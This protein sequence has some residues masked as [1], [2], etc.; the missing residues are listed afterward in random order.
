[1][2]SRPDSALVL[3]SLHALEVLKECKA[4]NV[5]PG[6]VTPRIRMELSHYVKCSKKVLNTLMTEHIVGRINKGHVNEYDKSG[7]TP[8]HYIALFDLHHLLG[9]LLQTGV[10]FEL[11]PDLNFKV[12]PLQLATYLYPNS[13]IR[14]MLRTAT[15]CIADPIKH[16]QKKNIALRAQNPVGA[17]P[18]QNPVGNTPLV[19]VQA[20]CDSKGTAFLPDAFV[21]R[22]VTNLQWVYHAD[23]LALFEKTKSLE[24]AH[25]CFFDMRQALKYPNDHQ[26]IQRFAS[27]SPIVHTK[28]FMEVQKAEE[29]L[30]RFE[31]IPG[32]KPAKYN[33]LLEYMRHTIYRI[34]RL[35]II[36][37]IHQQKWQNR[38]EDSKANPGVTS[39]FAFSRQS[40][41]SEESANANSCWAGNLEQ[42][43]QE[44]CA[45]ATSS[46][47]L[48]TPS[49]LG[50]W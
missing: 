41:N 3:M 30:R 43:A 50:G 24:D 12:N 26:I 22:I 44:Q 8:L 16:D 10:C 37:V 5:A 15:K 45:T 19:N 28:L 49:A 38:P 31:N 7:F 9:S 48:R 13:R 39:N 14:N 33:K 25:K 36:I 46:Q 17:L 18:A 20:K 21:H 29:G 27:Y 4:L 32:A 23:P 11:M 42:H 1:M 34:K 40:R 6:C 35:S 2:S 47:N